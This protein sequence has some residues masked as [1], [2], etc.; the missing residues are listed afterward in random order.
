M[1]VK[2]LTIN[3]AF[4]NIYP[5]SEC[6]DDMHAIYAWSGELMRQYVSACIGIVGNPVSKL[7]ITHAERMRWSIL[8]IKENYNEFIATEEDKS[9]DA[10][11][12]MFD[13][14]IAIGDFV[15]CETGYTKYIFSPAWFLRISDASCILMGGVDAR[16]LLEKDQVHY[17]GLAR[18]VRTSN[19]K[20][21][22]LPIATLEMW[23]D[24]VKPLQESFKELIMLLNFEKINESDFDDL[25]DEIYVVG[26]DGQKPHTKRWHKRANP[27][28]RNYTVG[29]KIKKGKTEYFLIKNEKD[30]TS[31]C[32][33]YENEYRNW[34]L[35]KLLCAIDEQAGLPSI[36]KYKDLGENMLI[37][38]SS[39]PSVKEMR[40]IYLLGC[41]E[42]N[43]C[44]EHQWVIHKEYF[45]IVKDQLLKLGFSFQLMNGGRK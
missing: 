34:D 29:R 40:L 22:N 23:L 17:I 38:F 37:H 35:R 26:S 31:V 43:I 16:Y 21:S 41:P 45:N 3:E 12:I 32:K 24:N 6:S 7:Q 10:V 19:V 13:R 8:Q 42:N 44:L 18:V 27:N 2:G 39:L 25:F 11:S 14:L 30:K 9:Q 28:Q 1:S 20:Q 33:F 5:C 4:N 15:P 36:V